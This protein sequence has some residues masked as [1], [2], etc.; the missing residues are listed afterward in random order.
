[1]T[2]LAPPVCENNISL[3]KYVFVAIGTSSQKDYYLPYIKKIT[4]SH[5]SLV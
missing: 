2:T 5:S 1:M 3:K 4:H